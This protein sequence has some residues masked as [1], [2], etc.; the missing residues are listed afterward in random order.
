MSDGVWKQVSKGSLPALALFYSVFIKFFVDMTS[1]KN[2]KV[3]CLSV[4]WE[5][6]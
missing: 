4:T 5:K 1:A 2:S 6:A 3:Q